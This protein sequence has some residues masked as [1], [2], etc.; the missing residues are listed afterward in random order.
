M[1]KHE[2]NIRHE[3][4]SFS[5]TLQVLNSDNLFQIKENNN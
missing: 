3:T 4:L 2:G 1:T 5:V